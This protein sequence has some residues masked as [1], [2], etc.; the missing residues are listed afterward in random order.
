[1]PCSDAGES[2]QNVAKSTQNASA[3][4]CSTDEEGKSGRE[5]PPWAKPPPPPPPPPKKIAR[6]EKLDWTVN[7]ARLSSGVGRAVQVES[8]GIQLTHRMKARLASTLEPMK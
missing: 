6:H 5:T 7:R 4:L 3:C 1:M 2:A 8:S